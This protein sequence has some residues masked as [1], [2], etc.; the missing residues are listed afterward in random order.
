MLVQLHQQGFPLYVCT[1]KQQHFA[2]RI[3]DA[4]ELSGFFAAIYGDKT[5]YASHSK[6]D[7][8]ANLLRDRTLSPGSSWMIGDRSFDID[9]ADRKSTRL[10]SSHANISYA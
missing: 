10:N 7:L 9:A 3:L 8:L 5:E 6:V 2:I 1:S 4:F